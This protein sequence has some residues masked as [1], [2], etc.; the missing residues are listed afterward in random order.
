MKKKKIIIIA[1]LVL[2]LAGAAAAVFFMRGKGGEEVPPEV[3]EDPI[4]KAPIVY[5]VEKNTVIALPAGDKVTVREHKPEEEPAPEEEKDEPKDKEKDESKDKDE[6][7]DKDKDKGKDKKKDK[8]KD[9]DKDK[10]ESKDE[11]KDESKD[12]DKSDD[13]EAVNT[14]DQSSDSSKKEKKPAGPE[15]T[16]VTTYR[17]EDLPQSLDRVRNYCELLTAEDFGFVPVDEKIMESKLP[18]FEESAGSLRLVRPITAVEEG[19]DGEETAETAEPES[20]AL[21]S[22]EISWEGEQCSVTVGRIEGGIVVPPEPE[23]MT[24]QE[25]M[26]YFYNRHPSQL[27]LPGESMRD[28]RVYPLDGMVMVG[29][30]ACMQMNVYSIDPDTG[31]TKIAGQYLMAPSGVQLYHIAS[32]GQLEELAR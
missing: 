20:E 10:D 27:G 31:T 32:D 5:E 30:T 23:P 6:S 28:Y 22:L 9:Q 29:N 16:V 15:I 24:L 12:K 3:K 18:T 17:Y 13:T 11:D 2:L 14:A 1:A 8:K 21:F 25:A 26:E 7:E 19:K 4:V